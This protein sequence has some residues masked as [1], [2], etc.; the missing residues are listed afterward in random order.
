MYVY[1]CKKKI[2][3]KKYI[4]LCTCIHREEQNICRKKRSK[5]DHGSGKMIQLLDLVSSF[6]QK[7]TLP[8]LVYVYV[9]IYVCICM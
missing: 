2:K 9:C 7:I 3:R 5:T 8:S 4:Y 6:S 1:I